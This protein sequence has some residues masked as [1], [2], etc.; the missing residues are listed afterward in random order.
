MSFL[1]SIIPNMTT[2]FF[3][4]HI[5]YSNGQKS[6]YHWHCLLEPVDLS[7]VRLRS[8][9]NPLPPGS[10]EKKK[11]KLKIPIAKCQC[12]CLLQFPKHLDVNYRV[13]SWSGW[14]FSIIWLAYQS[15]CSSLKKFVKSKC[16]R[17]K[18]FL[19]KHLP[20]NQLLLL[21][22]F[23]C[24]VSFTLPGYYVLI[25]LKVICLLSCESIRTKEGLLIFSIMH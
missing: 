11:K 3:Y 5:N 12:Q 14:T 21:L 2:I 9:N 25:M 15:N 13:S 1:K 7:P 18:E 8:G 10:K 24:T 6:T 16:S 17:L 22:F 20:Q 19:I 23:S 4:L